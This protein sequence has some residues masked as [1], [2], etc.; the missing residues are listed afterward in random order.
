[1][2]PTRNPDVQTKLL[3]DGHIVL[4]A[5]DHDWAHTLT[6]LG[7]IAWEFC[8]GQHSVDEIVEFVVETAG[9][10]S[11]ETLKTDLTTLFEE[12]AGSGLLTAA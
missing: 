11:S 8:D 4:F 3:P 12:L 2:K 5:K 1:V 10:Q 7:G 6:P 9:I